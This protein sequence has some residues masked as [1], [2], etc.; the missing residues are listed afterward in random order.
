MISA[1]S[2]VI[3]TAGYILWTLQRVYLGPEYKG[4]HGEAH[5]A[6]RPG[7]ELAIAAPLLAFAIGF[8]VYPKAVFGY[9]KPSVNQEVDEL[10]DW[11][12]DVKQPRLKQERSI[13][14]LAAGHRHGQ[15]PQARPLTRSR[16]AEQTES[17][18]E[19]SGTHQRSAADT[20]DVA[21]RLSAGADALRD[22]RR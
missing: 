11:T 1:A 15:P 17:A 6:D 3:L 8:G 19:F 14:R 2:V 16:L 22:D 5:Y 12:R 21:A 4:P 10:A 13:G 18:R 20:I 7:R 9:M